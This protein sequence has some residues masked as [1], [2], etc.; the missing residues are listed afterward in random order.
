MEL[1]SLEWFSALLSILVIDLVLAGDNAIVIGLAARRVPE[2]RQ[3]LVIGLGTLGA[4]VIRIAATLAVVWLLKIPGLYLIG[5][6]VLLWIAFNLMKGKKDHE[7]AAKHSVLAAIATIIAADTAMGLDNV[8]AVAGAAHGNNGLV[9]TGIAIS[10]PIVVWGSTVILR[11]TQRY[12]WIIAI[13]AA[14]LAYT[15][16]NMIVSEPSISF[17]FDNSWIKWGAIVVAVAGVLGLGSRKQVAQ[18]SLGSSF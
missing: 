1:L 10:I 2:K 15:A 9:I 11:L 5:G 8:L 13:G 7:I 17:V 4:I 12:P 18:K 14:V 6:L 16:A 3:K